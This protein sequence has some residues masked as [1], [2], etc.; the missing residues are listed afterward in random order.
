MYREK[1]I[2]LMAG[3]HAVFTRM[4]DSAEIDFS[5]G[6]IKPKSGLLLAAYRSSYELSI[7][8]QTYDL[9]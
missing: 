5:Q 4:A 1:V 6:K 7:S 3:I 2:Q 8:A 9:E